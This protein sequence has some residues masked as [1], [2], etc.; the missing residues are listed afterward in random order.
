MFAVIRRRCRIRSLG[1]DQ[2][3]P[4]EPGY[5]A[6]G[7]NLASADDAVLVVTE[8]CAE[9]AAVDSAAGVHRDASADEL[10]GD[11]ALCIGFEANRA[12]LRY[13]GPQHGAGEVVDSYVSVITARMA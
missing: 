1:F 10:V 7:H 4:P 11:D 3:P 6:G 5:G 13:D 12:V 8:P 9:T 2:L